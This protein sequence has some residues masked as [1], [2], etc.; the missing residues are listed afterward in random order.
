M[1][2]S[3]KQLV[4]FDASNLSPFG[5]LEVGEL[6][7]VIQMDFVYGINSQ[8]GL[9]TTANSATVDT[10]L[11][12]LRL[13]SGT[14]SAGSGIFNSR[15]TAKYRAGQ[16]MVARFTGVFA[17][18]TANNT[19][20]VGVG[21]SADG[22]FFGYNGTTFGI[23]H[24]NSGTGSLVDTWIA[25]SSWNGD[26][27]D[28]TGASAFTWN[29][30]LGNVM[31]IKYPYLGYG[32]I[33]FFVQDPVTSRF[34]LVHTI[35]YANT[36]ATVEA[37]NPNLFFYAQNLNSGNTTNLTMYVGSA[38]VFISG[39]RSFVGNPKWAT[40]NSKTGITAETAIL[41]LRNATTYNTVTNRGLIRLNSITIGATA[42]AAS[43]VTIK[44]KV[45]ATIGGS[46][47]F[48]T[49]N[50]TTADNG[51][52]ITSG[53]SISSVDTAGTT[54]GG[55]YIFN[56]TVAVGG[57]SATDGGNGAVFDLTPY[58]IFVAPAETLSITGTATTTAGIAVGVSWS[59]DI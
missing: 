10:N 5:T 7:P 18:G 51:V 44:L 29:K 15:K 53:N 11:G 57:G 55:N 39:K 32:D 27:A 24:R 30:Q 31:M 13:Q 38:S 14:N 8:T 46:P 20:I 36:L 2:Y 16:G 26:K 42:T 59:E 45:G 35:R 25:Q 3:L 12:R 48:T 4:Q 17:T 50:G 49:I 21:S 43:I 34:I 6:T 19:Q 52:T 58:E 37:S 41:N 23:L 54:S 22:Y 28:G 33:N 47:S 1:S 56:L 40:N 9:A